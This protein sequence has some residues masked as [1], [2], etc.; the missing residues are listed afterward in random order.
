MMM[1]RM[2]AGWAVVLLA[3]A[4]PVLAAEVDGLTVHSS[5]VGTGPTIVFVHGWT[6]DS[7]SWDGAGTG[8]RRELSRRHA[9]LAGARAQRVAAGR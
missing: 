7:S 6:C 9:R 8:V 1:K 3:S 5:A 4:Q 2:M